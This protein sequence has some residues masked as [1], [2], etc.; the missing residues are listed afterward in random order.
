MSLLPCNDPFKAICWRVGGH[1][2]NVLVLEFNSLYKLEF[3]MK[4]CFPI[5]FKLRY[6]L[7][8]ISLLNFLTPLLTQHLCEENVTEENQYA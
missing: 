6:C 5:L 4:S 3:K 2:F 8:S 7:N 1:R